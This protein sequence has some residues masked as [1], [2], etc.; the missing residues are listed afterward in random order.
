MPF[1]LLALQMDEDEPREGC[2]FAS[3][4]AAPCTYHGAADVS[5]G[6]N[7]NQATLPEQQ[8]SPPVRSRP[9]HDD[10]DKEVETIDPPTS[11]RDIIN[12][13]L[14]QSQY[15]C[16]SRT[17]HVMPPPGVSS[18][19]VLVPQTFAATASSSINNLDLGVSP[20]T[21]SSL[22]VLER[23]YNRDTW[24]MYNRISSARISKQQHRQQH[25]GSSFCSNVDV[26]N[27]IRLSDGLL[28]ATF[29]RQRSDDYLSSNAE[30]VSDYTDEQETLFDL[31]MDGLE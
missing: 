4:K 10:D 11:L 24:R 1:S 25:D 5:R 29:E 17:R 7:Q 6:N 30:I 16:S 12:D 9:A 2:S 8:H 27:T 15:S 19:P 23:E 26:E 20:L 18:E 22:R 14:A 21:S 3:S 31:E 28:T 13:G